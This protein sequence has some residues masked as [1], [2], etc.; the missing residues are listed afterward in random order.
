MQLK[1]NLYKQDLRKEEPSDLI[2]YEADISLLA[3]AATQTAEDL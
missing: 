1:D 3:E 2:E